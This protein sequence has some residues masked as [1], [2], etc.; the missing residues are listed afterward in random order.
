MTIRSNATPE[1]QHVTTIH[2]RAVLVMTFAAIV[3]AGP[4][5]AEYCPPESPQSGGMRDIML[6]YL[7]TGRWHVEDFTPYVAWLDRDG[8]PQQWFY[9]G[10]LFLMYGGAPSGQGYF[11]GQANASDWHYYLDLLF[12]PDQ[13]IAALD[14]SI[15][16]M[17]EALGE[18]EEPQPVIIMIPHLAEDNE[19]F[20]DVDGDGQPEDATT[21]EGRLQAWRWAVDEILRRWNARNWQNLELWGFY[22]MH[23]GIHPRHEDDVSAVADYVHER[24]YGLHWIPW[25]VAPGWD[26]ADEIGIDFTIMQPNFA[27]VDVPPRMAVPNEERL[28]TNANLARAEGLGVEME[29][30]SRVATDLG[31]LL[32][33]QLY[34]NHGVDEFDGYMNEAVRAYYQSS[35]LIEQLYRSPRPDCRRTY[36]DLY[37]FHAGTYQRRALSLA[38]GATA[39]VDGRVEPRLTDGLWLTRGER[40][41]RVP[42]ISG[43]ITLELEAAM[44][45]G[46]VRV[47]F[48]GN[49]DG[50]VTPMG[51]RVSTSMDG[52]TWTSGGEAARGALRTWNR[53]QSGFVAV[54]FKPRTARYVRVEPLG[55]GERPVGIDEV[56]LYPAPTPLWGRPY[57]ITGDVIGDEE[58]AS[59]ALTDGRFDEQVQFSDG[60]GLVTVTLEDAAYYSAAMAHARWDGAPPRMV[61]ELRDGEQR[62]RSPAKEAEGDGE[63]WVRIDLPTIRASEAEFELSSEAAAIWDEIVLEP[64]SNLAHGKPYTIEPSF[65]AKYPDSGRELTDGLIS[66]GYE[67]GRTV[68][69]YGRKPQTVVLDLGQELPVDEVRVHAEG[70]GF[71]AVY[72]PE[73]MKTWAST[74][75]EQWQLLSADEPQFELTREESIDDAERVLGWLT[76]SFEE[77]PAR[78]L[79]MTFDHHAWLMLSEIQAIS[80]G[81]NVALGQPYYLMPP[82]TSEAPY[83]DTGGKL[84]DGARAR[85]GS[86]WG[87][88]VGWN[89]GTPTVTVDLLAEREVSIIRAHCLGGGQGGVLF[90]ARIVAQTSEDGRDWQTVAT[91]TEHPAETGTEA[92]MAYLE[93]QIK[94]VT[95]R[96]VRLRFTREIWVMVTELEV[97]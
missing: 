54:A 62:F 46:D 47:H 66:I 77:T 21:A 96:Y 90:P 33:L 52:A 63:G 18:P 3:M 8:D 68:G 23:E 72:L 42:S 15:T 17:S 71:A 92:I 95:A 73:M 70:G 37:R 26:H 76:Q 24:G 12:A 40:V 16:R 20:G 89:T 5:L 55:L 58:W 84:T 82:P 69:W 43:P 51:V 94:P 6:C 7:S 57:E 39:R 88:A 81:E 59:I 25:Y 91:I 34:I 74:D 56:V 79:R 75:G 86:D 28:T 41:D 30:S 9:D 80:G 32:N 49:E 10:W 83:A 87:R 64:A 45:V 97:F 27:F 4:C 1:V 14:E 29:M 65:E 85:Y 78:L 38:E 48:A 22:W 60:E 53:W 11:G 61:V 93:A 50:P 2:N 13:N 35:D 44:I 19:A 31:Q 67:D 36:D